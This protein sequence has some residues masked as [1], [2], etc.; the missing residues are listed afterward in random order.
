MS[1]KQPKFTRAGHKKIK[2][3]YIGRVVVKI[4]L[5]S[6]GHNSIK[7]NLTKSIQV[8]DAKVSAVYTAIEKALFDS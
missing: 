6:S 2:D 3:D 8:E 5:V 1:A 7:G 4:M